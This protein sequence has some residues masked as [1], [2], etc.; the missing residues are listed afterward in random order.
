MWKYARSLF[1]VPN[2]I[3]IPV[4]GLEKRIPCFSNEAP[5]PRREVMMVSRFISREFL[6]AVSH[7]QSRGFQTSALV[8]VLITGE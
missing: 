7:L 5:N 6:V 2:S 8:C 4:F 1:K 3:E